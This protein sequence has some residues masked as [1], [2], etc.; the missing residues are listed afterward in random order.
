MYSFQQPY[1]E[2]AR[3]FFGEAQHEIYFPGSMSTRDVQQ[4]MKICSEN[5]LFKQDDSRILL[6][7][8]EEDQYVLNIISAQEDWEDENLLKGLDDLYNKLAVLFLKKPV[9]LMLYDDWAERKTPVPAPA[10]VITDLQKESG[11]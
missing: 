10:G 3:Q 8:E 1:F 11:R 7:E 6:L 2:G 5:E 9:R 4:I